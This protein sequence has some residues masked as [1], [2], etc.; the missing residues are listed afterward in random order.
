MPRSNEISRWV[1]LLP[2]LHLSACLVS[3]IGHVIPELQFLGIVWVFIMLADLPVS[4]IAYALAWNHGMIAGT[5]VVVLGTLW[6]YLLSRVAERLIG[7]F[8]ARTQGA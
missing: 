8:R 1:Y 5:W 6:W 3:M 4:A 7:R 2:L